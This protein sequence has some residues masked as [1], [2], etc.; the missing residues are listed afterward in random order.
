MTAEASV[1]GTEQL[2]DPWLSHQEMVIVG[3]LRPQKTLVNRVCV[4][5]NNYRNRG[6]K[7]EREQHGE[8]DDSLGGGG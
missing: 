7:F 5:N 1:S 8:H 2:L 6:H 4:C 3:L